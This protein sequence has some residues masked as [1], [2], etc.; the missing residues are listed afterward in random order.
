VGGVALGQADD[1][2]VRL[3]LG[4]AGDG[5]VE[6]MHQDG[7]DLSAG[8]QAGDIP[9]LLLQDRRDQHRAVGADREVLQEVLLREVGDRSQGDR[10]DREHRHVTFL[11]YWSSPTASEGT[12]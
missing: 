5:V 7:T 6:G 1:E 2:H 4:D 8:L 12:S 11:P 10:R 3:D 9:Q